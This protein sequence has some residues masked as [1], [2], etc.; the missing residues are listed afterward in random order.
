M[1]QIRQAILNSVDPLASLQGKV[2]TGVSAVSSPPLP[3]ATLLACFALLLAAAAS[4]YHTDL[5]PAPTIRCRAASMSPAWL[6]RPQLPDA[7]CP[8]PALHIPH[9]T[10]SPMSSPH[11]R[12]TYDMAHPC[13]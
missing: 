4:Y 3:L 13:P 7:G 1:A 9:S 11:V 10:L 2:L 5:A 12:V 6:R 8:H